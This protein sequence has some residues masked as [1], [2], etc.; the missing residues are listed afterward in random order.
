MVLTLL[1]QIYSF[2]FTSYPFQYLGDDDFLVAQMIGFVEELPEDWHPQ[3]MR[4]NSKRELILEESERTTAITRQPLL[5]ILFKA[6]QISKLERRFKERVHDPELAPLFTIIRGLVRFLPS[7][8]M[9]ASEALG[10]LRS[11]QTTS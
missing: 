9:N 3:W 8:R 2:I 7:S 5:L 10:L 6:F 1:I 4:L 11:G